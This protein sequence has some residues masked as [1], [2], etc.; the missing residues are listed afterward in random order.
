VRGASLLTPRQVE[1]LRLL[2]HG[3]TEKE[4]AGALGLSPRTVHHH[5]TAIYERSGVS[6]RAAVALFAVEHGLL[7]S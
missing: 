7:L 2:A 4:I 5:V 1:V 6:S 3:L